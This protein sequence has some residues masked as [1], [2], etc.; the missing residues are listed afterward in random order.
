MLAVR[1]VR[2]KYSC[3]S[4]RGSPENGPWP[5]SQGGKSVDAADRRF[6]PGADEG[7]RPYT[8]YW[9]RLAPLPP[10]VSSSGAI[11][12]AAATRSPG[13][14]CSRR[15]PWALRPDSRIVVESMRMILP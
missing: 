10:L 15:T 12:T 5:L 7:V 14:I 3:T 11:T 6:A 1:L 13:S 9:I 4:P 8:S 2:L